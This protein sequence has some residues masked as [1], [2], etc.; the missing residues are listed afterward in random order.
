VIR[1]IAYPQPKP[2]W[3]RDAWVFAVYT[4]WGVIVAVCLGVVLGGCGEA[5]TVQGRAR[6]GTCIAPT[7]YAPQRLDVQQCASDASRAVCHWF[8][9]TTGE[10]AATKGCFPFEDI[11]CVSVCP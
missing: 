8:E 10:G 7:E 9:G 3:L 4:A 11:E 2:Q 1:F 5:Q 6:E